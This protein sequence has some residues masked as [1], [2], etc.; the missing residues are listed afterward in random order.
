M[1]SEV[2]WHNSHFQSEDC[3]R[4]L[5]QWPAYGPPKALAL[6]IDTSI[7]PSSMYITPILSA[8]TAD[9]GD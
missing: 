5:R 7:T 8:V 2:M 9:F 6:V 4:L 3:G 1:C